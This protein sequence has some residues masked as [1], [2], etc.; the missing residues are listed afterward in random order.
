MEEIIS[1]ILNESGYTKVENA[2]LQYYTR[3]EKS[4]FFIVNISEAHFTSLKSKELIKENEQY[5]KVL[6]S[7]T[8]IVNSGEQ[9]TIEKNSSLIILVKCNNIESIEELQQQILLFEEDEYFFKKYVILY[10]DESIIQLTD[11]P[12]VPSLR[13]KVG[14]I[15]LFNV[16]ASIGYK[17]NIAEYVVIIELFIKL[18][19]LS[20]TEDREG[21]TS[22]SEKITNTLD[23]DM[24]G[25]TT[26]LSKTNEIQQLDFSRSEDE[27]EI[28]ELLSFFAND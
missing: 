4:Y 14:N 3:E 27:V 7:F 12:L 23:D 17:T 24:H 6:D 5:K 1:K 25:Y 19:F 20:L 9:I 13:E 16:F 18:P 15:E 2:T 28:N 8:A 22:L 26:L 10:T 11:N 21:F